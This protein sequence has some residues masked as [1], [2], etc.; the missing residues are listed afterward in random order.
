MGFKKSAQLIDREVLRILHKDHAVRIAHGYAGHLK[1]LALH[2]DFLVDYPVHAIASHRNLIPFQHRLSHI[3]LNHGNI[4]IFLD[5]FRHQDACAGLNRKGIPGHM[6][7]LI[8]ITGK[9]ADAVAA[10]L[11]LAA[12]RV[13]NPH[14]DIRLVR[15]QYQQ[16]AV[17][18]NAIMPV[19]DFLCRSHIRLL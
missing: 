6:A 13:D 11:R 5:D 3:H 4:A 8:D 18:T 7:C 16:N 17:R 14:A 10:H 2:L 1:C 15:W 19:A 9:A 12:V